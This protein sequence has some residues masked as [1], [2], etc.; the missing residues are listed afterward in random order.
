MICKNCINYVVCK[1][2][3]ATCRKFRF[4]R[5]ITFGKYGKEK[6]KRK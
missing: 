1:A 6:V 4:L 2:H 3:H 5:F